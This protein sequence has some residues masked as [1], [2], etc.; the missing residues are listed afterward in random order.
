MYNINYKKSKDGYL[1][2]SITVARQHE[3][4][5]A[6]YIIQEIVSGLITEEIGNK[7]KLICYVTCDDNLD[8]TVAGIKEYISQK[9]IL[10]D[11]N[12]EYAFKTK[13]VKEIDWIEQY[14]REFK[15]VVIDDLVIKTP[16]DENDYSGKQIITIEPKMAFGTGKHETT[17][18]SLQA[19]K[20]V[21]E[22]GMKILDLGTG[23]GVLSI[24]AAML[25]AT[26]IFGLD[27][28]PVAIPNAQENAVINKIDHLYTAVEGSM[29]LVPDGETYDLVISNL[30][31]DGII[32][33][34]ADFKSVLRPQGIMILSGV[35]EN[36]NKSLLEYF[37]N[38]ISADI[39][40]TQLN[41]W[42]CYILRT[43]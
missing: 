8:A 24:Y 32:Q 14:Q 9:K 7:I 21:V 1:E 4:L 36:Q 29:E 10:P 30:I 15:S 42:M 28:D 20:K 5:L 35:L 23:S 11:E 33:L 38:N 25:G 39:E 37:E 3:E 34:F 41:E 12:M 22:Q 6:N 13:F 31:Y 18:L 19:V 27:I 43:K 16:W 17:H 2:V 40:V 26:E